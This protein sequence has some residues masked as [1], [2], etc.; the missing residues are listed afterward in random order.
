MSWFDSGSFGELNLDEQR[1]RLEACLDET[2]TSN[3]ATS[4]PGGTS[5]N[6]CLNF[7]NEDLENRY[8]K[9]QRQM[10]Y[11][12]LYKKIDTNAP[13]A[14]FLQLLEQHAHTAWTGAETIRIKDL[15]RFWQFNIVHMKN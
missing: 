12:G 3:L 8:P 2:T 4:A 6:A 11:F 7:L 5:I 13:Y 14:K 10:E 9:Y 1:S 15:T